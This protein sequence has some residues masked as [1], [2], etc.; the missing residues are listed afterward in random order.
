[1][2]T[3]IYQN[4]LEYE[5]RQLGHNIQRGR[6]HAPDIKGYSPEYLAAESLRTAEIKRGMEQRGVTGREAE[7]YVKHQVREEKLKLTPDELRATHKRN[8]EAFGNQPDRVVAEASHRHRRSLSAEEMEKR[9]Q[10][11][12]TFARGRL[13]ERSAVFEHF[14]VIRDAVRHTHGRA[15]LPD[16]EAALSSQKQRGNFIEV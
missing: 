11:A 2:A 14:E 16:V 4:Q 1:M 13:S 6:N 15:R 10:A 9:S 5:L 7:S 8:A 12:V 3:A